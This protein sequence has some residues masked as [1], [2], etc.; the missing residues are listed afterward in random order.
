VFTDNNG[1]ATD[2]MRTNRPL[3]DIRYVV[4]VMAELAISGVDQTVDVFVN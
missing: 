3:D 1:Q 4:T 2:V